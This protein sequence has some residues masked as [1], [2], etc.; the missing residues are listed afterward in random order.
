MR[1]PFQVQQPKLNKALISRLTQ[2]LT[3]AVEF[4]NKGENAK[5]KELYSEVVKL[6]PTNY[7]CWHILGIF[8]YQNK[9]FDEALKRFKK[10]ISI[11]PR[12]APA[13]S[14]MGLALQDLKQLESS[15]AS[16]DK[17]IEIDPGLFAAHNNR[18][19]ALKD[20]GLLAQALKSYQ[21]ALLYCPDYAEALYNLAETYKAL[22][23][24]EESLTHY[25]RAV[26][27]RNTYAEAFNNRGLMLQFLN[28][29][30]EA[31]ESFDQTLAIWPNYAPAH[32]NKSLA[33]LLKGEYDLGWAEHE[34]RWMMDEFTS[35]KRNFSQ[36]QWVGLDSNDAANSALES[37]THALH[38]K[39]IL[40]HCEQGLGDTLQFCRYLP[41]LAQTGAR[42]LFEVQP[43]LYSL[44][45][46]IAPADTLIKQGDHLPDFDFHCP[47]ISLPYALRNSLSG[48]PA[49]ASYL[50]ANNGKIEEWAH[51][52]GKKNKPRVGYLWSG[53]VHHHNDEFRS[54]PL[55]QLIPYL[56]SLSESFEWTCLQKEFRAGEREL[57]SKIPG[58][59]DL[60]ESIQDFEDTA[61]LCSLMDLII[62][63]DTS[64]A[65]LAGAL[66]R[67][68]WLMLPFA[69]DW[70]WLM[71]RSDSPWYPSIKLFRQTA[72]S[73]WQSVLKPITHN[74]QHQFA[75]GE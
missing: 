6:Q 24:W 63:V 16:Y 43:A 49:K 38:G 69:P 48:I 27:S 10:V 57:L 73:D 22:H 21:R 7:E 58:W 61:A 64:V 23:R 66:G 55:K 19:N 41:L 47:L 17:A 53:N 35:A 8:E 9:N 18:G 74:L 45:T 37:S 51:K 70:R 65:H 68:T 11:N 44:M 25:N 31:I 67:P 39:T 60:S 30:D 15:I 52:L 2:L 42:V 46:Q 54:L 75:A 5:A 59:M 14:N 29:V 34:W 36:P 56:E 20:L 72:I 28:R 71:N 4:Q 33:L 26:H 62:T 1:P 32:S 40:I 50:V 12:F 13:H 3:Q